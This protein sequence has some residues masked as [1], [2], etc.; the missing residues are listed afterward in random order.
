MF[1]VELKTLNFYNII[2]TTN[3]T[4]CYVED[5]YLCNITFI[6]TT[7]DFIFYYTPNTIY[8]FY[9]NEN[10][11]KLVLYLDLILNLKPKALILAKTIRKEGTFLVV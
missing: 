6:G 9:K 5:Y 3:F 10:I 4:I 11:V 8:H 2:D 1:D 7:I